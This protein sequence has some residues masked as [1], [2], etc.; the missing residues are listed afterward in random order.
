MSVAPYP[1]APADRSRWIQNLRGP[2]KP[3]D[4]ERPFAFISERER[5][6]SGTIAQVATIF[7]TNRECPWRC[8]MCDLWRN[9]TTQPVPPGA[10]IHQIHYAL[11]RLPKASVLKLYNSGS[12]F[13]SGAIP[14]SDYAAIAQ[15]GSSFERVIVECHPRLIGESAS[16]FAEVMG[17]Q[18]EIAIGLET[19]HPVALEKINKRISL[20][21]YVDAVQRCRNSSIDVRTFLLVNPPF[22]QSTDQSEWLRESIRY[23]FDSGSTVVSLIPARAGNGAL[24]ELVRTNDFQEPTLQELTKGLIYGFSLKA[25]NVFA[26]TWDLKRFSHCD[27]C[28]PTR[29][30][31][32][33]RMNLSQSVEP[34]IHCA[35]CRE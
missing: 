1:S 34:E 19:V 30:E 26:D 21:D 31:Q 11:E 2:R 25:G 35:V 14:Q 28:F 18:L 33:E 23:A 29:S 4:P 10:I 24:D 15:L 5:T 3:V 13:D 8:V 17:T 9:T 27:Q 16:A 7:L 32:I 6:P 22:V 20:F 12:F